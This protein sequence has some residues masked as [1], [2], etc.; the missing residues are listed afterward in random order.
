VEQWEEEEGMET[1]LFKKNNSIQDSEGNEDNEYP[2]PVPNKTMINNTKEHRNAHKNII[3]EE[4]LQE[5]TENFMEKI[6]DMI[7]ENVQDAQ[8]NF[9]TPKLKNKK[10]HRN[11]QMNTEAH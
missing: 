2:V 10:R 9:N 7:N 5:I 6:I 4:I 3:K 1:T 11:K 8:R